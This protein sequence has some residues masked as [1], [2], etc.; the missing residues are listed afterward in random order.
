M[1]QLNCWYDFSA[2]K[3]SRRRGALSFI[4]HSETP[5][6]GMGCGR[7]DTHELAEEKLI[8]GYG[9][10]AEF[11]TDNGFRLSRSTVSKYCSPATNTGPP[12]E[13]YWGRLPAFSPSRALAW[14]RARLKPVSAARSRPAVTSDA[15]RAVVKGPD[16]R[17][18]SAGLPARKLSPPTSESGHRTLEASERPRAA[19]AV[20]AS[21]RH[22]TVRDGVGEAREE[23]SE[24]G[25]RIVTAARGARGREE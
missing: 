10:L 25:G 21:C 12:V 23:A 16:D 5:N 6:D 14:A 9:P 11:L 17:S 19:P 20:P 7:M 4:Q 24:V 8:V 1:L 15:G 13:A 3:G 22:M 18:P 2:R